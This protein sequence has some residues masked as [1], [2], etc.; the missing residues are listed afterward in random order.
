MPAGVQIAG[1]F[2]PSYLINGLVIR[3]SPTV[4]LRGRSCQF[5]RGQP[6]PLQE[7]VAIFSDAPMIRIGNHDSATPMGNSLWNRNYDTIVQMLRSELETNP[8]IET[9]RVEVSTAH[10]IAS[11]R[12]A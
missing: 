4:V 10:R 9:L 6:Q 3:L 11:T 7:K 12:A 2:G 5:A 1:S 8:T